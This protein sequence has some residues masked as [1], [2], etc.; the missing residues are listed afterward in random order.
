MIDFTPLSLTAARVEY[1]LLKQKL[2]MKRVAFEFEMLNIKLRDAL[3]ISSL[4]YSQE[5][6]II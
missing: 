1:A 5:K 2:A 3:E 6:H 4:F